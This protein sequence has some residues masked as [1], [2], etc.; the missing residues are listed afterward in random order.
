M[1]E[2]NGHISK[3]ANGSL[4]IGEVARFFNVPKRSDNRYYLSD[5]CKASAINPYAKYKSTNHPAHANL[6][7]A[8]RLASNCGVDC[9]DTASGCFADNYG[10]LLT[11]ARQSAE[12]R[13]EVPTYYCRLLDFDGYAH[14]ASAPYSPIQGSFAGNSDGASG[15]LY[16]NFSLHPV[17]ES[18]NMK[19]SDLAG[20]L[21]EEGDISDYHYGLIYRQS[22]SSAS[23]TLVDL[24]VAGLENPLDKSFQIRFVPPASATQSVTYEC[25]FI[26]FIESAVNWAVF[27]PKT[28]FT[29][30]LALF[31]VSREGDTI[32]FP[33]SGGT[34][35]IDISG[36]CWLINAAQGDINTTFLPSQA[37]G[38]SY[39]YTQVELAV[40]QAIPNP[41]GATARKTVRVSA[42]AMVTDPTT[43]GGDFIKEFYIEQACPVS[44]HIITVDSDDEEENYANFASH[45]AGSTAA[46]TIVHANVPWEVDSITYADDTG[47][48]PTTDISTSPVRGGDSSGYVTRTE[49]RVENYANIPTGRTYRIHFTSTDPNRPA[50]HIFSLIS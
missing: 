6:T 37:T 49:I 30:N 4:S 32:Q 47:E 29:L 28:F 8:E 36:Y 22:G 23:P 9:S 21:E 15:S 48:Y 12:W 25:V 31:S 13:H 44:I 19:L 35:Y 16:F 11:R 34:V 41:F 17:I 5:V 2:S 1:I 27:I 39:P 33:Q 18:G 26:A 43:P 10:D 42:P 7:V 3:P 45:S 24:G 50:T 38:V 14:D 20:A 46:V 40:G